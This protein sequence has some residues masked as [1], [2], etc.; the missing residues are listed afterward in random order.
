M[1]V[2]V[3]MVTSGTERRLGQACR[4]DFLPAL[5]GSGWWSGVLI[6]VDVSL[7]PG[8]PVS[9]PECFLLLA[10]AQMETPA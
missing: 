9:C 7:Y 5:L 6:F 2:I 10:F 3:A 4:D 1:L 8:P